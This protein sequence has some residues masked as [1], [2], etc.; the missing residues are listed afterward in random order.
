MRAGYADAADEL[1]RLQ[2]EAEAGVLA[3]IAKKHTQALAQPILIKN[4]RV[5]DAKTK[6]LGE[7]ADVYVNEGRIAAIYAGRLDRPRTRRR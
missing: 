5:F 4:V 1:E 6:A 7:P 2:Q 3:E